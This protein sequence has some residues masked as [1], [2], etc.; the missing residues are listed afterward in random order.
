[1]RAERVSYF[2]GALG[3]RPEKK[4]TRRA[5]QELLAL[6]APTLRAYADLMAA[7]EDKKAWAKAAGA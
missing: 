5:E 1:A 3:L 2:L 6:A 7:G 4:P